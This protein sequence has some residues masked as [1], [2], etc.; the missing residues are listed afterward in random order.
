MSKFQKSI[1]LYSLPFISNSTQYFY[2]GAYQ[3]KKHMEI[4]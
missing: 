1:A 4:V 2:I 3:K